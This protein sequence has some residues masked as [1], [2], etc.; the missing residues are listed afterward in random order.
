MR[1]LF[2]LRCERFL[3]APDLNKRRPWSTKEALPK[4]SHC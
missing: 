3:A 4:G 2:F 1:V